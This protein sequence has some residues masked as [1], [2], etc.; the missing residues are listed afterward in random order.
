VLEKNFTSRNFHAEDDP[1]T[2]RVSEQEEQQKRLKA[3]QD[4]LLHRGNDLS[5]GA[6]AGAGLQF[7]AAIILSAMAGMWLDKRFRTEPWLLLI[8][9]FVGASAGFWAMYRQMTRGQGKDK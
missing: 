7:G 1:E 9:V 5:G 4:R 6:L 8:T 3:E 2:P